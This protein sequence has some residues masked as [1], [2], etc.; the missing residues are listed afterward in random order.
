LDIPMFVIGYTM[1][2]K[3]FIVVYN[4]LCLFSDGVFLKC[5]NAYVIKWL[6]DVE[7]L[8]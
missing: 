6:H 7:E 2:L 5:Q 3:W 8:M 1:K 4:S